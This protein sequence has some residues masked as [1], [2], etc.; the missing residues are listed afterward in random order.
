MCPHEYC[1]DFCSISHSKPLILLQRIFNTER[2]RKGAHMVHHGGELGSIL[3]VLFQYIQQL[4]QLVWRDLQ[5]QGLLLKPTSEAASHIH[6]SPTKHLYI[7]IFKDCTLLEM[8]MALILADSLPSSLSWCLPSSSSWGISSSS[9]A[10]KTTMTYSEVSAFGA[11]K[12]TTVS[13]PVSAD[14]YPWQWNPHPPDSPVC[15]QCLLRTSWM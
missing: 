1:M 11:S 12:L 13:K 10:G 15:C 3:D 5:Q 9:A 7:N 4:D 14:I 8:P 6:T 2:E